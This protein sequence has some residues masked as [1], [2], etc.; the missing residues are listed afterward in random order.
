MLDVLG[1]GE[2]WWF[3]EPLRPI[4]IMPSLR[5]FSCWPYHYP[6]PPP[7]VVHTLPCPHLRLLYLYWFKAVGIIWVVMGVLYQKGRQYWSMT[8]SNLLHFGSNLCASAWIM[9]PKEASWLSS[10]LD[11]SL[12]QP[13]LRT[14]DYSCSCFCP[15]SIVPGP[16][17]LHQSDI[18][19]FFIIFIVV[20]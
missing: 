3:C 16:N 14:L 7:S 6:P 12:L 20:R 15:P 17:Y 1:G 9:K 5:L 8:T 11:C 2:G 18:S 10:W 4:K 13:V 19:L